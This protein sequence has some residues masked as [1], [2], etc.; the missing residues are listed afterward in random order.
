MHEMQNRMIIKIIDPAIL[1]FYFNLPNFEC[2]E[3]E[4]WEATLLLFESALV[5]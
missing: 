5:W 3:N 4:F 2:F 1:Q